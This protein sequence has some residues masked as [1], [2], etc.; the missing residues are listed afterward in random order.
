MGETTIMTHNVAPQFLELLEAVRRGGVDVAAHSGKV[1]SGGVFVAAAG[2]REDGSRFIADALA[3]GAAFVVAE[4]SASLPADASAR[5]VTVADAKAALGALAGARY[6]TESM[7]MPVV[8]VTGTNG[9]TTVAYLIERLA[10]A[11]GRKVGV[12]GTVA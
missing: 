3:R 7:A 5:L 9:K 10:S 2:S 6:G 1:A 8:A 12:L 11:A 4:E